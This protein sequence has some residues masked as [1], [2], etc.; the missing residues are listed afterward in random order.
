MR[1]W[2]IDRILPLVENPIKPKDAIGNPG[3]APLA[4][5]RETYA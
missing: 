3:H 5:A 2:R 4:I 1:A